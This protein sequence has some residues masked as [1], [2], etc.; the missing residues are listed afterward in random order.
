MSAMFA[1]AKT[2]H[3]SAG[4][5]RRTPVDILTDHYLAGVAVSCGASVPDSR[6]PTTTGLCDVVSRPNAA[7]RPACTRP[8]TSISAHW[9]SVSGPDATPGP[10]TSGAVANA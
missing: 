1:A 6:L 5:Y 2:P 7:G 8:V 9:P 10:A 3:S 4:Q